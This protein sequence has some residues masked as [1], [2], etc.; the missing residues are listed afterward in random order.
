[1]P[2]KQHAGE[3]DHQAGLA[4]LPPEMPFSSGFFGSRLEAGQ[5]LAESLLDYRQ[6]EP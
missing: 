3:L 6:T 2:A 1:M 5:M 4:Y